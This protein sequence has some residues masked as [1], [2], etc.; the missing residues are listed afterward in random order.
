MG[1]FALILGGKRGTL[2]LQP[3]IKKTF[4]LFL[5]PR[6]RMCNCP[7]SILDPV[8]QI[9]VFGRMMILLADVDHLD[10]RFI[11][12]RYGESNRIPGPVNR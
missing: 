12:A 11:F 7:A 2:L 10:H 6:I 9:S 1:A 3:G 5:D 8:L 4:R